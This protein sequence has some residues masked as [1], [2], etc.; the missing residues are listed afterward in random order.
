MEYIDNN[1]TVYIHINKINDKKYVGITKDVSRRWSNNGLEYKKQVFG[2][3]IEKYGWDNFEHIIIAEKL[4]KQEACDM[5]IYLIEKYN[6]TD[7]NYG[8]NISLGGDGVNKPFSI[9]YQYR[10]NGEY[11][12]SGTINDFLNELNI[13]NSGNIYHCCIGKRDSAHGYR[14][15]YTYLGEKIEELKS[16]YLRSGAQ[17]RIDIY[18]YSLDGDFIAYY[19]GLVDVKNKTGIDPQNCIYGNCT[20][21]A[22]YQWFNDYMGEKISP[23]L[24]SSEKLG[25]RQ[26]KQVLVFDKDNN[27]IHK[28]CKCKDACEYFN[29]YQKKLKYIIDNHILYNDYYIVYSI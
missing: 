9:I 28:F 21:T 27:L 29:I 22:G 26:S 16:C 17:K 7:R 3:A 10:M 5:E 20:T 13:I 8:Y 18:Q 4:S 14:W 24:S 23:V 19:N 6:T 15:S 2:K 1:Y 12:K 11:V 25:K